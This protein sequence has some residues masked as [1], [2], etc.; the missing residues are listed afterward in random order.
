MFELKPDFEEVLNR[1]EAWWNC[2]IVDRP[3]VSLSFFHPA[4]EREA[5]PQNIYTT[6]RDRWM[7]TEHIVS[8]A[9]V[10]LRNT[11]WLADSLPVAWPNLG[12]EVFSAFYGC[13]VEYGEHT[14]WRKPILPDWS[15]E[16]V[17]KL[18]L[19]IDGFFFQKLI[20][21]TDAL[22]EA[23]KGK[24]IVGYTDLHG[25]GDAIAALYWAD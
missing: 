3:L 17:S 25:G 8:A 15:G 19:D 24:F 14:A 12:P 4:A 21:M 2:E 13:E 5:V 23:G 7:D 20:E 18:R 22:I 10:Q 9:E 1:Y 6:V 16:S 11:V